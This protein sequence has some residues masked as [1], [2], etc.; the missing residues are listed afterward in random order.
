M[1]SD[2]EDFLQYLK[3]RNIPS[4]TRCHLPPKNESGAHQYVIDVDDRFRNLFS[5]QNSRLKGLT[6]G[7]EYTELY[8][9]INRELNYERP[10]E[11]ISRYGDIPSFSISIEMGDKRGGGKKKSTK[12]S[13]KN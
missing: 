7:I 1:S 8:D 6:D 2:V 10:I 5:H 3:K 12:K 9:R 11:F 13:V 4:E